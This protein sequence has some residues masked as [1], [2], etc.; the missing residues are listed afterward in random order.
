MIL[1]G[2][3]HPLLVHLPIG[4]IILL[5]FLELLACFDRFKGA[6]SSSGFV[7]A[8]AVPCSVVAAVC[9]WVLSLSGE[10]HD[11][12]LVR[13]HKIAGV[14]TSVICT[15]CALLYHLKSKSYR[16]CL[17]INVIA[18]LVAGHLGGSLSYG[19]SY[20]LSCAPVFFRN[21]FS[22][23]VMQTP[24]PSGN[25]HLDDPPSFS[26]SIKP[27]LEQNCVSCHGPNRSKGG[28]RLDSLADLKEGGD[29]GPVIEPGHSG[30][31]EIIKRLRLPPNSH[32][33]MPPQ[34]KHQPKP[35]EITLLR[36][37]IDA[38]APVE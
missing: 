26:F 31:S 33:H 27:I 32:D 16:T 6:N 8:L 28:L 4:L 23:T 20:L 11:L 29:D 22:G 14:A 30:Q 12:D 18:V 25:S 19:R 5:G 9:G 3:L 37:W 38:G 13:W 17:C 10:Y 36:W 35:E 7:L 2:H 34:D 24:K 21:L 1:L 15:L